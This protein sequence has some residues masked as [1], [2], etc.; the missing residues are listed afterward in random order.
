[1]RYHA[2]LG[3]VEEVSKDIYVANNITNN[4]AHDL[5]LPGISH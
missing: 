4:L 3:T 5:T 1:M 2:G